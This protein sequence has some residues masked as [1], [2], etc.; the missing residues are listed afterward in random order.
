MAFLAIVHIY[1]VSIRKER[2]EAFMCVEQTIKFNIEF[3]QTLRVP[4]LIDTGLVQ[5]NEA[6]VN[7]H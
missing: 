3:S 7:S 5:I 1:G 4:L 2:K 6:H